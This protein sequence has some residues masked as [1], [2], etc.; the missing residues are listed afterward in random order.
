MWSPPGVRWT[1]IETATASSRL[2]A[3]KRVE[4]VWRSR[5]L[6]PRLAVNPALSGTFGSVVARGPSPLGRKAGT[7]L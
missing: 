7:A 4:A 5:P 2:A 6:L 3:M 1:P